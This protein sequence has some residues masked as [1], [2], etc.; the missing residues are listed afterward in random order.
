MI[1]TPS[2]RPSPEA[3]N[4]VSSPSPPAIREA[5]AASPEAAQRWKIEQIDARNNADPENPLLLG[6][7]RIIPDLVDQLP[8]NG[9]GEL[10]FHLAIFPDASAAAPPTLRL[11]LLHDGRTIGASTPALPKADERGRISFTAGVDAGKFPPG[12][13]KFRA[14]I[15]QGAARREETAEFHI[16]GERRKEAVV[17]EK[18][19]ASALSAG[20]KVGELTLTALKTV[21]PLEL[22]PPDLIREALQAGERSYARLGDYTYSLRKVRRVLTPKGKIRSEE[23]NDY[24]AYPIR[25]KHAL[26][27]LAENGSRLPNQR[28]DLNR[29]H[30]TDMLIRSDEEM[31]RLS[32]SGEQELN[33][34]IGYWGASIEGQSERR[35]QP[36][37]SVYVTIDPEI[38][39][40][41]CEFSSPRMVRLES[42]DTVVLDFR[43]L[44]G[45]K[46]DEDKDW[47]GRLTGTVWIDA[48]DHA[49]VRIEGSAAPPAEAAPVGE[50]PLHFVYQQVRLA[51][52]IW[53]PS[54]IRINAAGDE[55]LFRGLNWDAWFQFTNYKR[56][57]SKESDVKIVSPDA[58]Q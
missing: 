55:N 23:Y 3:P 20:D 53:G 8:A 52:G 30:A 43:P 14:L 36:R 32:Q 1:L 46:L 54:L 45:A 15:Q 58:K 26:I 12:D 10:S 9:R 33:R 49:L 4:K 41:S 19:I 40:R 27:H 29:R 28:I 6:E 51:D 34:K 50:P 16:P 38:F 21:Q 18:T 31:H 44:S 35:G 25:G 47:I 24:E 57:D 56:F 13:Y 22:S 11:E 48:A 39:F 42:R 5:S 7:K 17:E 2:G 37:R